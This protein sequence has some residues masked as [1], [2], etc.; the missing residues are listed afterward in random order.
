LG[1]GALYMLIYSTVSIRLEIKIKIKKKKKKFSGS[2]VEERLFLWCAGLQIPHFL[3][4]L[5]R[6]PETLAPNNIVIDKQNGIV[7]LF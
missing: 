2:G 5:W 6:Y 3:I 7:Y 1:S 4:L